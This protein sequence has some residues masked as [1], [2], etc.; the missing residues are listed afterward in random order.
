MYTINFRNAIQLVLWNHQLCGQ[1]SDGMWEN[2]RPHDHYKIWC[3]AKAQVN[4][5]N[6][7]INF[8]GAKTNY[9][10]TS[11]E[12]LDAVGARMIT[13]VRLYEYCKDIDLVEKLAYLFEDDRW[14][15]LPMYKGT[16]YDDIRAVLNKQD[17]LA[18]KSFVE[19]HSFDKKDLRA[20]LR[21]MKQIIKMRQNTKE[22]A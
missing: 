22:V 3:V 5:E 7:G 9:N 1:I 8:Y 10:F 19:N 18:I 11:I 20:E 15:G 4:P 13:T 16:Y 6:L 17:L 21:D 2:A 14:V 12:L